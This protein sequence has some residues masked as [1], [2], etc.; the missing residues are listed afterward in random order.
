VSLI[1][2]L[3]LKV[4]N[5]LKA[6]HKGTIR[7][8]LTEL[9]KD[10][11]PDES[12]PAYTTVATVLTRLAAKHQVQVAEVRFRKNQKKLVYT[13]EDIEKNVIDE[14]IYRLSETFGKQVVVRLAE[15]L[16]TLDPKQLAQL[17]AKVAER[18][19]VEE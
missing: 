5:A 13:Y 19:A 14:M 12:P 6:I 2:D 7:E 10:F 16:E 9:E 4:I 8:I 17:K 1:G 18:L 11:R 15:R 3:E